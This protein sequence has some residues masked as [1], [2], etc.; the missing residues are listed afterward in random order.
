MA[1][2]DA[3]VEVAAGAMVEVEGGVEAGERGKDGVPATEAEVQRARASMQG[4]W[5]L[6]GAVPLERVN[7]GAAA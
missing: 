2:A 3:V 5:A 4:S 1:V 6:S 7:Y